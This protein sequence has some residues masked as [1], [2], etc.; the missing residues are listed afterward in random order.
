MGSKTSINNILI[1]TFDVLLRIL[2]TILSIMLYFKYDDSFISFT[3]LMMFIF[4]IAT[5]FVDPYYHK[6]SFFLT[7]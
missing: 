4:N 1:T 6:K 3:S 7:K 5:T 2:F